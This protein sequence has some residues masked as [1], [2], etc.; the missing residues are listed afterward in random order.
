MI[1]W[2]FT[3]WGGFVKA[4]GFDRAQVKQLPIG[5][6]IECL[7][8]DSAELVDRDGKPIDLQALT[9]IFIDDYRDVERVPPPGHPPETPW[10]FDFQCVWEKTDSSRPY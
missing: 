6:V 1:Q 3:R 10:R 2:Y 9:P 4:A 5:S 7:Q 8:D